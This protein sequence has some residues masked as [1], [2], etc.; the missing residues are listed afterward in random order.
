MCVFLDLGGAEGQF[1]VLGNPHPEP[2]KWDLQSGVRGDEAELQQGWLKKRK[3]NLL[4]FSR[5]LQAPV[6]MVLRLLL[7]AISWLYQ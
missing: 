1:A 4:I 7:S 5:F 6:R 3:E 2:R